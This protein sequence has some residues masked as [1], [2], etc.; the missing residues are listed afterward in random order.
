MHDFKDKE[1]GKI[2]PHGIYDPTA[3]AGWVSKSASKNHDRPIGRLRHKHKRLQSIDVMIRGEFIL[4]SSAAIKWLALQEPGT[5]IGELRVAV[6]RMRGRH[7][8]V[9]RPAEAP[10]RGIDQSG[11]GATERHREAGPVRQ[12]SRVWFFTEALL[13]R[14]CAFGKES[15]PLS[16][17]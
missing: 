6:T 12:V 7:V 9:R 3:N 4:S 15:R 8:A 5:E 2:V 11:S 10:A 14:H 17:C 16:G 1:K 13:A